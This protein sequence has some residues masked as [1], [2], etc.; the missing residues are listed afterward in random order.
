MTPSLSES[1][2]KPIFCFPFKIPD[3]PTATST[4]WQDT[5]YMIYFKNVNFKTRDF[6]PL[7]KWLLVG[8]SKA[9]TFCWPPSPSA[10][11]LGH[12]IVEWPLSMGLFTYSHFGCP[13]GKWGKINGCWWSKHQLLLRMTSYIEKKNKSSNLVRG[14]NEGTWIFM[15]ECQWVWA[16]Y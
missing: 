6:S 12:V 7:I 8:V 9:W 1:K 4:N 14:K 10:P 16:K 2:V 15:N 11:L 5:L 3:N 13:R